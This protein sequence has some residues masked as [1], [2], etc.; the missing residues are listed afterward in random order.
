MLNKLKKYFFITEANRERGITTSAI[1][2]IVLAAGLV[3]GGTT[4]VVAGHTLQEFGLDLIAVISDFLSYASL[5]LMR[6]SADFL[7]YVL[8]PEF[9][10]QK[11]TD[12]DTFRL[13][14]SNVRDLTNMLIVLGFVFI[15]IAT[16]IRWREYEAKKLLFPLILVAILINFSGLICQTIIDTA[17]TVTGAFI[18]GGA[19]SGNISLIPDAIQDWERRQIEEIKK[20]G[21]KPPQ[22]NTQLMGVSVGKLLISAVGAYVLAVLGILLAARYAILAVFY[23]LSPLAMFAFV[24]PATKQYW[25]QWWQQFIRWSFLGTI[26]SFLLYLSLSTL[27][28]AKGLSAVFVSFI[29]IYLSYKF[30]KSGSAIGASAILSVATGAAGYAIGAA[31]KISGALGGVAANKLGQ[32]SIGQKARGAY[33]RG[34]EYVGMRKVG[35]TANMLKEEQEKKGAGVAILDE[36]RKT[37]LAQGKGQMLGAR[38]PAIREAAIR[39][40]VKNGNLS[41]LSGDLEGQAALDEQNKHIAWVE[42]LD[43]SRGVNST[44]R[45]EAE[46]QNPALRQFNTEA[47]DKALKAKGITPAAATASQRA[48]AQKVVVRQQFAESLPSMGGSAIRG[49][50]EEQVRGSEGY[51][52]VRDEFTPKMI[53]YMQTASNQNLKKE[54][55]SHVDSGRLSDD[56]IRA[57]QDGDKAEATR[58]TKLLNAISKY[59]A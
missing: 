36:D 3:A 41:D 57:H 50:N 15:G 58:L 2:L 59:C 22:L 21:A 23:I 30:A 34:L 1:V 8:S 20:N 5:W 54:M 56:I 48:A 24:F 47:V 6:L 11:V 13:M 14:W 9:I 19:A 39:D 51:E 18:K 49:I 12:N 37:R 32:S 53:R 10:S 52:L 42:G 55:K 27:V 16:T 43:K 45:R 7:S 26:A 17:D 35:D 28:A 29:F 46:K 25:T 4:Y 44:I 33:G 31:G 38:S 40:K